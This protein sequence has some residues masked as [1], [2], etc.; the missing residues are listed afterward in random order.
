MQ[1]P[2]TK[3]ETNNN[4]FDSCELLFFFETYLYYKTLSSSIISPI[5]Q[6]TYNISPHISPSIVPLVDILSKITRVRFCHFI[7]KFFNHGGSILKNRGVFN[8]SHS[9]EKVSSPS[10]ACMSVIVNQY[11]CI[12]PLP[13]AII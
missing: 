8:W 1:S 10:D 6:H 3:E 7:T 5:P 4:W 9:N 11:V 2:F 13:L 12:L